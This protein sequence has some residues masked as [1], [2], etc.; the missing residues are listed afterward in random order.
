MALTPMG[1]FGGSFDPV[2]NGHLRW[3][4][5]VY[6]RLNIAPIKFIPARQQVL[7]A[8]LH[9]DAKHRLQMLQIAL[10]DM[11]MFEVDKRELT[12]SDPSYTINSLTSL[13]AE[14]PDI[15]LCLIIGSDSFAQFARWHRYTEILKLAHLI[16][17]KRKNTPEHVSWYETLSVKVTQDAFALTAIQGGNIYFLD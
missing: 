8:D 10:Q 9:T 5:E 1:I 17:I 6:Q 12:S 3:A 7:K 15:P 14:Y 2:H 16:V 11:P 13:R 4:L